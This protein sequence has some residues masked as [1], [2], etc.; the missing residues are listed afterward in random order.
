M[1]DNNL[2]LAATG[3]VGATAAASISLAEGCLVEGNYARLMGV[4][5]LGGAGT[6]TLALSS[7]NVTSNKLEMVGGWVGREQMGGVGAWWVW[8]LDAPRLLAC[9][10]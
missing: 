7:T 5:A 4:L 1:R 6:L 3:A 8:D 9:T 2:M 10:P